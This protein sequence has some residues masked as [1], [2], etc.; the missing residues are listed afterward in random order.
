MN[1]TFYDI[2]FEITGGEKYIR[3]ARLSEKRM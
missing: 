2:C 1:K 3:T